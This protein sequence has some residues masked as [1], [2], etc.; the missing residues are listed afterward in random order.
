[1]FTIN[2]CHTFLPPLSGTIGAVLYGE[3]YASFNGRF[4]GDYGTTDIEYMYPYFFDKLCIIA[5]KAL[6]IPQWMAIFKCFSTPVWIALLVMN[7]SCGFF[8]F[9]LKRAQLRRS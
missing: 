5:P 1:M 3:T 9:L 8:W 4:M 7:C 6:K 2:C